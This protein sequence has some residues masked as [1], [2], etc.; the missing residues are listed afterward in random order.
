MILTEDS[1]QI[2]V[3]RTG[4]TSLK[5]AIIQNNPKAIDLSLDYPPYKHQTFL[6]AKKYNKPVYAVLREPTD[7]LISMYNTHLG[8]SSRIDPTKPKLENYGTVLNK[9]DI[10]ELW[11]FIA[12]WYI[13]PN[14]CYRQ[15]DWIGGSNIILYQ[16]INSY[17]GFKLPKLNASKQQIV[18]LDLEAMSLAKEIWAEDYKLYEEVQSGLK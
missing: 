10:L 7:W 2:F 14:K 8:Q 4:S 18:A 16:D 15:I 9:K 5:K 17:F 1:V 13:L 11:C 3:P 12:K 6:E